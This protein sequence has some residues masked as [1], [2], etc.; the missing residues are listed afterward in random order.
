MN[1]KIRVFLLTFLLLFCFHDAKADILANWQGDNAYKPR[2]ILFLHGIGKGEPSN[3]NNV[4][5][6]LQEYFLKYK[7]L[8]KYLQR[9]DFQD[10]NGSVDTYPDGR[11]G[12]ADKVNSKVNELLND[13]DISQYTDKINI[14]SHSMGGLAAR[15]YL[16][17]QK[18]TAGHIEKLILIGTPNLG[19]AWADLAYATAKSQKLGF[20]FV[21]P[22]EIVFLPLRNTAEMAVSNR[23]KID[24]DGEAVKDMT[25]GNTFLTTLNS[26]AQ[27]VDVDYYGICGVKDNP[28]NWYIFGNSYAGDAVVSS[29]SQLG[30]NIV[31]K[32]NPRIVSALHWEETN[33]SVDGENP[34]LKFLDPAPYINIFSPDPTIIS[35]IYEPLVHVQG[36]VFN[37]YLPADSKLHLTVVRL[38]DNAPIIDEDREN[39]IKPTNLWIPNNPDSAVAEYD[40][41][42]N[43]PAAG[44]YQISCSVK[45]PAGNVSEVQTILVRVILSTTS[46]II[47]H[48]H[49][50]EGKEIDSLRG[51]MN[52]SRINYV[53]IYDED[54][55]MGYGVDNSNDHGVKK[56]LTSNGAHTIKAV[57]NGMTIE[58]AVTLNPNEVKTITFTFERTSFDASSLLYLQDG[59][60]YHYSGVASRHLS[61][62]PAGPGEPWIHEFTGQWTATAG[63]S[64]QFKDAYTT[65][66]YVW[67]YIDPNKAQEFVNVALDV[68]WNIN[69]NPTD[70]TLSNTFT[71]EWSRTMAYVRAFFTLSQDFTKQISIPEQ[72][73]A[74]WYLHKLAPFSDNVS[75]EFGDGNSFYTLLPLSND[76]RISDQYWISGAPAKAFNTLRWKTYP[77]YSSE[78]PKLLYPPG[79]T[80]YSF[81]GTKNFPVYGEGLI[82]S[83]VPY[84]LTETGI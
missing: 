48:C 55:L 63:V 7:A 29:D 83:S 46:S 16:T 40:E 31:F 11:D 4:C 79:A 22:D 50:P 33:V 23:L 9:I 8:G 57:F 34:L 66:D 78:G 10:P 53:Q 20:S 13:P 25:T 6:V 81:T 74:Y 61:S 60:S 17:N 36:L 18:Y 59:G 65:P 3:W 28:L 77:L 19:S 54:R 26:R 52:S 64:A 27:P 56:M 51:V 47:V 71:Y 72:S 1:K 82:M 35:E 39:S 12:W 58:Q 69:F 38:D 5:A 42:I 44:T 62:W 14:V 75:A 84:D 21:L 49:N 41:L 80:T 67:H 2:P 76:Y 32:K 37:E 68:N 15:E 45:N 73:F 30:V 70:M 24:I 43:F